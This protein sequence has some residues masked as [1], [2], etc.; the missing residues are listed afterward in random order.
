MIEEN[1]QAKADIRA[2]MRDAIALLDKDTRQSASATACA[3]MMQL[4]LFDQ[5]SVVMLYMP[6]SDEVDLLPL[7]LRCFQM[8]KTVC[9]P[10]VDWQRKDMTPAEVM[11]FDDHCM[12]VDEHGV[13]SPRDG[14]PIVISSIDLVV[15]PGLA[16]DARGN[17]L[18][19]GGGYYDRFLKRLPP[20][21]ATVGL[22][23]DVQIIDDVP[24]DERDIRVDMVV[25]D[26]RLTVSPRASS[27]R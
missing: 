11:S 17:R 4:E 10:K 27:R 16:F 23:F 5:A 24:V 9:V 26:R 7:A 15:V 3:R 21:T 12:E 19:R 8:G 1:A 25:T 20:M 14:R 13:R 22:A 2:I 18:G 6:L